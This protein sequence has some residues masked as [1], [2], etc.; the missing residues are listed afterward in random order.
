M[1]RRGQLDTAFPRAYSLRIWR[2]LALVVAIV[3][4]ATAPR[5]SGRAAGGV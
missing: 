3:S 4:G 1:P 5:P 2:R